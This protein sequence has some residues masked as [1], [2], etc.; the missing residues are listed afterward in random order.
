LSFIRDKLNSQPFLKGLAT[1]QADSSFFFLFQILVVLVVYPLLNSLYFELADLG[2]KAY[3][4]PVI[5]TQI[6]ARPTD[7]LLELFIAAA[8]LFLGFRVL[9]WENFEQDKILRYFL[10]FI[11]LIIA[12]AFATYDY[13]LYYNQAH[14]FDRFLLIA[15]A[16]LVWLHPAFIPLF[17]IQ[18]MVIVFQFDYPLGSY[19][20][21]DKRVLFDILILFNVFLY[22]KLI[23]RKPIFSPFVFLALS[24]F[25]ANYYISGLGKLKLDWVSK[26]NIYDLIVSS[27]VNGWLSFLPETTLLQMVDIFKGL[28][29]LMLL[30]TMA[31]ELGA[32]FILFHKRVALILL[33]SF[34]VLHLMIFL[35]SGIFFWKWILLAIAFGLALTRLPDILTRQIFNWPAFIISILVI[36]FSPHYFNPA[37]LAWYDTRLNNFYEI[38]AVGDTG[39]IYTVGRG[40]MS[41]YD[42]PFAQNRFWYLSDEK[43][44]VRTYGTTSDP[45][46]A[47]ALKTIKP[48]LE[49]TELE[50]AKGRNYYN[51]DRAENFAQFLYVYF[52]NLNNRQSKRLVLNYIAS[53]H[54]IWNFANGDNVYQMQEKVQKVQVRFVKTFYDGQKIHTLEDRIVRVITVLPGIRANFGDDLTLLDCKVHLDKGNGQNN[55]FLLKCDWQSQLDSPP[56]VDLLL[57]LREA[58]TSRIVQEWQPP[59]VNHDLGNSWQKDKPVS[60][61][62]PLEVGLLSEGRYHLDV[63][64]A[65]TADRRLIPVR[66]K[67]GQEAEFVRLENVQELLIIQ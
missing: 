57:T 41:P 54:H 26:N 36:H 48:G 49:L 1:I 25:A 9:R 27:Y 16:I 51:Q 52:K 6:L 59:L 34:I 65:H 61:V 66:L 12:W 56:E 33:L 24:L 20:W 46:I 62:H 42:F 8:A 53:P 64:L 67:N 17:L 19:S 40:F 55:L 35:T 63:A 18:A 32:I 13:N 10:F 43:L 5:I 58:D 2:E 28:D 29:M 31:I 11:A 60:L 23:F 7:L 44:L 22:L 4:S 50:M 15:L 37:N 14:Y 39:T 38:Q 45:E 30:A 3:F 21:T 47:D